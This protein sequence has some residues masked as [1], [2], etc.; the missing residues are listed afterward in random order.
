MI[1]MTTNT[2][3]KLIKTSASK[4]LKDEQSGLPLKSLD[5]QRCKNKVLPTTQDKEVRPTSHQMRRADSRQGT[6]KRVASAIGTQ[7]QQA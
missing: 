3:E 1:E 6:K 2:I 5:D 4:T 7:R